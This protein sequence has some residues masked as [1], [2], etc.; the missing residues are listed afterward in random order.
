MIVLKSFKQPLRM[1]PS[2][3][4][5]FLTA[6][7]I[8]LLSSLSNP[9]RSQVTFS[10]TTVPSGMDFL[11][12]SGHGAVQVADFNNDGYP[13]F[14]YLIAGQ[15]ISYFQNFNGLSFSTPTPHPFGAVATNP[16]ASLTFNTASSVADFDGDG[17]LD[18]WIRVHGADNDIY[19]RNNGSSFT[20]IPVPTGM[21]YTPAT[22][23]GTVQV[24]DIN[25]DGFP[26]IIYASSVA[27]PIVYLQ[28]NN[29]T[30]FSTPTPNPFAAFLSSTPPGTTLNT[31]SDIADFDGDGDLD[32][33]VRVQGANNDVFLRN[34][35][36]TYVS[37][38]VLTGM[39]FEPASTGA[40]KVGDLNGD[41][42]VDIFY[43]T[44]A[45]GSTVYLQNNNGISFSTPTPNP[46]SAI[47]TVPQNIASNTT[48][49]LADMD[50]D[51]DLDIWSRLA[52][53]D[54]DFF[55]RNNGTPPRFLSST[56]G[57]G[58]SNVVRATNITLN[59]SKPVFTGTGSFQIRRLA[60]NSIFETIAANGARVSG[61]GSTIIVIDPVQN[62]QSNTGYYLTFTRTALADA[63]GVIPGGLDVTVREPASTPEFLSFNTSAV[64]PATFGPITASIEG[65]KLSVNFS[66]TQEKGNDYF[67]I[68]GSQDGLGFT[69]LGKIKSRAD[70]G[71]SDITIDYEFSLAFEQALGG[72]AAVAILFLIPLGGKRRRH[73]ALLMGIVLTVIV[74]CNKASE[75][76]TTDRNL[77]IRITQVDLDGSKTQ[78]KVIKVSRKK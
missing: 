12:T 64:L 69:E 8:I 1:L 66:T 9:A 49:T 10:A 11:G 14:V 55:A 48:M 52:N 19:F 72:A 33:W 41:G 43:L 26:D 50:G 77:Y 16:P 29:G 74:S 60:D 36:G 45:G 24:A 51:G 67:V 78:S 42:L 7:G 2:F 46:F 47:P 44:A 5:N 34:D 35:N 6:I 32:I 54:N 76:D 39:D 37:A 75:L 68:E 65:G 59:F 3:H 53:A 20:S 70:N 27:G 62:L 23:S 15:G 63:Q 56:P 71:N 61:S 30:S 38:T 21:E 73:L 28:N 40:V 57:N 22:G 58:A 25:R 18:I 17:D 13:D 31:S 4:F